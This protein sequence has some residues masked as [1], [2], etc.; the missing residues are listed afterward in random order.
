[1]AQLKGTLLTSPIF[2]KQRDAMQARPTEYPSFKLSDDL[3]LF[4]G[5]IWI[6]PQNPFIPALLHEYHATPIGGHLGVKKTLH[7]LHLNFHWSTMANDVKHFVRRCSVCQQVKPVTKK[8]AGLLQPIPIPSGIWEDLSMDFITHFPR[9]NGF[10]IIF[11]FVDRFSK[12]V[13]L[14][15][16]PTQFTAFKVAILFLDTVCKLHGFPRSIISDRDPIFVSSFW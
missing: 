10:T 7:R 5:A 16:L 6:D 4:N 2:Q 14:G 9:S 15:T 12:G 1:M 13:H 11:V 3:I 8:H